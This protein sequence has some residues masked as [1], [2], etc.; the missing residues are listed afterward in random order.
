MIGEWWKLLHKLYSSPGH[1]AGMRQGRKVYKVF[2]G[3][4]E[5]KR[6]LR[7]P[8]RRREDG[9][10]MDPRETGRGV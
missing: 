6:Q 2:V 10:R 4:P 3:K 1:V 9:I 5:G 8:R 7:R